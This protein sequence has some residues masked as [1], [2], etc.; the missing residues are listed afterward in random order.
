[1]VDAGLITIVALISPFRSERQMARE[2]FTAGDFVEIFIDTPLAVCE[3]RDA[4]GLYRRARAGEIKNFTGISSAYEAPEHPEL[5]IKADEMVV[6][7]IVE[8]ITG[9]LTLRG[10]L[11]FAP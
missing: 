3:A 2:R 8:E 7:D 11:A 9:A 10:L 4:K 5:W 1:M 6:D